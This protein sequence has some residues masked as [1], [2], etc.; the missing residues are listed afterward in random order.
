MASQV[1]FACAVASLAVVILAALVAAGVPSNRDAEAISPC[2]TVLTRWPVSGGRQLNGDVC[3]QFGPGT[4]EAQVEATDTITG[5]A[6]S[7]AYT[8][9]SGMDRC[10]T[11]DPWYSYA[12]GDATGFNVSFQSS[13]VYSGTYQDCTQTQ[14]HQY[15]VYGD[16]EVIV[17]GGTTWEGISGAHEN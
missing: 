6:V 4:F 14:N 13:G 7:E 12:S 11:T 1:R 5:G 10:N 3:Q 16:F 2:W 17:N 15:R 9:I 8:Y